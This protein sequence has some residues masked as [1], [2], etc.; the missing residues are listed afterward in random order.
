MLGAAAVIGL[1]PLASAQAADLATPPVLA[2]IVPVPPKPFF[3][4][5]GFVEGFFDTGLATS[6]AG[7]PVTTGNGKL[8]PVP[9]ASVEAG[10]FLTPHFAV[11]ISGGFPPVLSLMGTGS[12]APQGVLVKSQTGV[13]TLTGHYHFD[14]GPFKPYV[15]GGVAYAVVLRDLNAAIVAPN[16]MSNAGLVAETG[17]DYALTDSWGVFVDFKK[18]WL[19]QNFTGFTAVPGVTGLAPVYA[20]VRTDPILLTTGVSYRF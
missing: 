7:S 2:P 12:F 10:V 15:G 4:R 6:I 8:S 18:I 3:V 19:K 16:L 1:M 9:T 14:L 20:R 11:S 17:V 5:L 13:A